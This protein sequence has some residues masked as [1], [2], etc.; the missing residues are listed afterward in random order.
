MS[1]RV[2]LITASLLVARSGRRDLPCR[3][4]GR[5]ALRPLARR[6]RTRDEQAAADTRREI[7]DLRGE[8][9]ALGRQRVDAG[10]DVAAKRA[11]LEALHQRESALVRR[12]GPRPGPAG[13]AAQRP[14]AVPPRSAA[15]PAGQPERRPRRGAG[16]D[17]DPRHDPGAAGPRRRL[18]P[19]GPR[20]LGPAPR[21]RRRLR[22][23]VHRREPGRRPQ[24]RPGADDR[25]EDPAGT[26]LRPGGADRRRPGHAGRPDRRPGAQAGH[27][28]AD[29]GLARP[30]PPGPPLRPGHAGRRP[31]HRP[32]DPHGKRSRRGQSRR[33][34][35]RIR[36]TAERLGRGLDP[37]RPGR[38]PSGAGGN[39]PGFGRRPDNLS[40]PARR[41]AGW[42]TMAPRS[43]NSISRF[44]KTAPR[45]I[46]S[47][48]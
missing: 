45:S 19:P 1:R 30:R 29:P 15:G 42:R 27:R 10:D 23:A 35:G 41:L 3:G 47:V 9:D 20:R 4:P 16:R 17:P 18:R 8:L 2:V 33:R 31:R 11:R 44:G 48:G 12:A 36:R 25:R 37:A 46:R 32:D 34:R 38:L 39:G 40:H 43:Q 5:P 24:G 7:V 21:G 13:P 26:R 14:A 22:A 6:P 28:A